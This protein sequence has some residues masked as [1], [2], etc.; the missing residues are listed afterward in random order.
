MLP[1]LAHIILTELRLRALTLWIL[2]LIG[3][4]LFDF[5][6]SSGSALCMKTV[7]RVAVVLS[8]S[9]LFITYSS[10][11]SSKV[12][13]SLFL[14]SCRFSVLAFCRISVKICLFSPRLSVADCWFSYSNMYLF[15][16]FLYCLKAALI[17]LSRV[18]AFSNVLIFAYT[19]LSSI[20]LSTGIWSEKIEWG[21]EIKVS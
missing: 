13:I 2:L 9:Y 11:L 7:R 16:S 8:L 18:L 14:R 10:L 1:Q 15:D 6:S 17:F 12:S 5:T 21:L 20:I 19:P 4:W 3:V